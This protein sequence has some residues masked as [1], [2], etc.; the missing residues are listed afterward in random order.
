MSWGVIVSDLRP[1]DFNEFVFR[2]WYATEAEAREVFAEQCADY[3]RREVSIVKRD[4]WR[5][6]DDENAS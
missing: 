6:P 1:N 4:V 5:A 2:G 3:P